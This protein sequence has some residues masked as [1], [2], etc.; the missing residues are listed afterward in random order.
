M[1][2]R[3]IISE[4]RELANTVG[5]TPKSA[6]EITIKNNGSSFM[7][8]DVLEEGIRI[9]VKKLNLLAETIENDKTGS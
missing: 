1:E 6:I 4:I 8:I 5:E 3:K 9:H 7:T 2:T